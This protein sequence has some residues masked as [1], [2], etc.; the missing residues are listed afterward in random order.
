M[1]LLLQFGFSSSSSPSARRIFFWVFSG[2]LRFP[3]F[4]GLSGIF[5]GSTGF[6]DVPVSFHFTA[7]NSLI[8]FLFRFL[9]EFSEYFSF[10]PETFV[11]FD[12]SGFLGTRRDC[13]RFAL[14]FVR[15]LIYKKFERLFFFIL[16]LSKTLVL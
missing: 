11:C 10:C 4:E 15:C 5:R 8:G 7:R 14:W 16:D 13:C 6:L 2:Y 1:L 9:F 12:P 3:H